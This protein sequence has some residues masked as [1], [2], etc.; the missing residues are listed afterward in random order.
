VIKE[1]LD[2]LSDSDA[3]TAAETIQF[4]KDRY[5]KVK[6][7]LNGDLVSEETEEA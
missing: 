3:R 2:S 6:E 4:I 1:F 7:I 5:P